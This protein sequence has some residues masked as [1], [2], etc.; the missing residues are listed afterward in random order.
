MKKHQLF[1]VI[2]AAAGALALAGCA[3]EKSGQNREISGQKGWNAPS[4]DPLLQSEEAGRRRG[5][6]PALENQ[7]DE[8][9]G[10]PELQENS[11]GVDDSCTEEN[12][13]KGRGNQLDETVDPKGEGYGKGNGGQGQGGGQG[14][15][16]Q[17]RGQGG[18]G[19]A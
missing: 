3:G 13:Q 14:G 15:N 12:G 16:G 17:G 19:S 2:L 10:G 8:R 9:P 5:Q 1:I 7:N 6:G 11:E 4:S 18:R